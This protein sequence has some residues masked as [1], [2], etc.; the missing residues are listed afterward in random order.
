M[1]EQIKAQPLGK[2]RRTAV[3]PQTAES[4]GTQIDDL[5]LING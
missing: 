2:S 4:G 3:C 5:F 1:K